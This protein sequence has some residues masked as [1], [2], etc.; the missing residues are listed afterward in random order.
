MKSKET[1]VERSRS[2]SN[3]AEDNGADGN[4]EQNRI[5]NIQRIFKRKSIDLSNINLDSDEEGEEYTKHQQLM[6]V[7]T[8]SQ[9]N[10]TNGLNILHK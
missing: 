8:I 3:L 6:P 7:I 2:L 10:S 4:E 9:Y 1:N 5:I